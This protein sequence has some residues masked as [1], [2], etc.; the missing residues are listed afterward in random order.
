M[1]NFRGGLSKYFSLNL[2]KVNSMG[3]ILLFF[4][5]LASL[6]STSL[7]NAE[8]SEQKQSASTIGYPAEEGSGSANKSSM[9]EEEGWFLP[10]SDA[11]IQFPPSTDEGSM[12]GEETAEENLVWMSVIIIVLAVG[13]SVIL[14]KRNKRRKL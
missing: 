4:F 9:L 8:I 13:V 7:L 5:V 2:I 14:Y 1:D 12:V 3:K 11:Q 6:L 10:K